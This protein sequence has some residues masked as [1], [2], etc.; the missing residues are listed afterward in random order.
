MTRATPLF[1]LHLDLPWR[2]L[3]L[4]ARRRGPWLWLLLAAAAILDRR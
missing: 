4:R 3:D 2:C 1:V